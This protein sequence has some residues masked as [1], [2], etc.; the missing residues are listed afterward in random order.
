MGVPEPITH[1]KLRRLHSIGPFDGSI[2]QIPDCAFKDLSHPDQTL[3]MID[4]YSSRLP[5]LL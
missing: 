3:E 4:Y 2:F 1:C 5:I